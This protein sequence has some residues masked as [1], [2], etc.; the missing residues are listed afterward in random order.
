MGLVHFNE[1]IVFMILWF[2]IVSENTVTG[3][4]R[5]ASLLVN[6][7]ICSLLVKMLL[8]TFSLV[9]TF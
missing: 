8:L 2:I 7:F 5:H 3:I 6:G 1:T 9:T 4:L